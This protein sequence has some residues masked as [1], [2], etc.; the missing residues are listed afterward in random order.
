MPP[1]VVHVE[2]L[3][4]KS[5]LLLVSMWLTTDVCCLVLCAVAVC[6]LWMMR[7]KT[8]TVA[9]SVWWRFL[10][11]TIAISIVAFGVHG[12]LPRR[13]SWK[14]FRIAFSLGVS[15]CGFPSNMQERF[16]DAFAQILGGGLVHRH[17][18][19]PDRLER[20]VL[21][22]PW[23]RGLQAEPGIPV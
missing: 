15:C 8:T 9:I 21:E 11:V 12:V 20:Q 7:T 5:L 10:L 1:C 22:K 19:H 14:E 23:A 18:V 16:R 2:C 13:S 3:S 17:R 6:R 4:G